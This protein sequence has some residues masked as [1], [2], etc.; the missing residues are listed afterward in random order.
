MNSTPSASYDAAIFDFDGVLV[1]S[2]EAYRLALSDAVAPV[3][4]KDWPRLFGMTTVEAV[5][6]AAG[7]A[8]PRAQFLELSVA[9]DRRVGELLAGAPPV[10][11]GATVVLEE[12]RRLGL[13]MAVASSASRF[14]ID[15]ALA[16]L[17]WQ[18]YFSVVVG[19]EDV[20]HSKPYPDAY[21]RAANDLNVE[22][23][24]A[25]AIEDTVI[26]AQSARAAGLFV[27]A[28]GGTQSREEL[29]DA[30]LF[31]ES[32]HDLRCSDWY[33]HTVGVTT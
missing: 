22:P 9:I 3:E 30:D 11:D 1:D 27:V 18:R 24:A 29:Q 19:R 4:C 21:V 2:A 17:D 5:E 8:I 20:A 10:R 13:A 7:D 14:A 33:K 25:F 23:A 16:T 32:F 31:F 12:L 28:L 6:F 26:G 15:G